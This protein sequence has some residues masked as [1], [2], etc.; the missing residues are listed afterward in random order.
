M[1]EIIHSIHEEQIGQKG[2]KYGESQHYN[3]TKRRWCHAKAQEARGN[4]VL[5]QV[6]ASYKLSGKCEKKKDF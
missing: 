5:A 3:V 4:K 1:F 2:S 6:L